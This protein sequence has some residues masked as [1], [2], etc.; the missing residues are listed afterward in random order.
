MNEWLKTSS[1]EEGL[2]YYLLSRE[3]FLTPYELG[4][5]EILSEHQ[6]LLV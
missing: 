3:K 4:D 1:I 2:E 6:F 5:M